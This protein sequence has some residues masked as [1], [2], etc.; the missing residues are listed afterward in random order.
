MQDI[1]DGP[2]K[3]FEYDALTGRTV[4]VLHDEGKMHF[5]IDMPVENLI[6]DNHHEAAEAQGKRLGDFIK[7]ASIPTNIYDDV[8]LRQAHREGDTDFFKRWLNDGA[9]RAWRTGGGQV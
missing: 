9:N 2:W 4:W 7:V 6:R 1:Y 5:R 3:L 8:G